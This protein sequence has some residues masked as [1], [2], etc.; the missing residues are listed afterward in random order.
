MTPEE[1]LKPRYE[2]IAD[3]PGCNV[4]VGT[5]FQSDIGE[6]FDRYPANFRKLAWWE[7]RKREEL[8]EYVRLYLPLPERYKI[9]K[10]DKFKVLDTGDCWIDHAE[11]KN[12][13]GIQDTPAT[14]A[15][16]Q[17]YLKSKV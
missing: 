1:L 15:E 4:E 2:V 14:E 16:Y 13:L 12:Y 6:Y 3:Y 8:P 17:E 9:V 11:G 5:I 7:H 10:V